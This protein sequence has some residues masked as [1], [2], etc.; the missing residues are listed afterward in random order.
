MTFEEAHEQIV[1]AIHAITGALD[2]KTYAGKLTGKNGDVTLSELDIDS[3]AAMAVCLEIENGTG[4][5]IDLGWR[6]GDEDGLKSQ[7]FG[8]VTSYGRALRSKPSSYTVGSSCSERGDPHS[9]RR[10]L[11]A[12]GRGPR[13]ETGSES[14]LCFW[15]AR[16]R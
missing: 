11:H 4:V 5:T 14:G 13:P 16:A 8:V 1:S 7:I 2:D 10:R 15:V 9:A 6:Y 12:G 3:L